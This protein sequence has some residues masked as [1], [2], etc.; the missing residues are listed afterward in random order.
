VEG[1]G[2]RKMKG[3]GGAAR[4]VGKLWDKL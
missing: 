3:S 4:G 2:E 1:W